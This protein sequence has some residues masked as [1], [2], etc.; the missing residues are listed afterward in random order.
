MSMDA[1]RRGRRRLPV[2]GEL[3]APALL[4]LAAPIQARQG[5]HL[6][7]SEDL[8]PR[9]HA[10][11]SAVRE[12]LVSAAD[13]PEGVTQV[14]SLDHLDAEE[15][16]ELW[17]MLGEG[18]VSIV[19][20]GT[21]R[22]EIEET[23]LPGVFRVRTRRQDGDSLHLEVGTIPAVVVVAAHHGTS[24]EM[25]LEDP[26]PPGLMNAQPLLAELKHR[27]ATA[28]I[29]VENHVVSLSLLPMNDADSVYLARILG[30]G[31][32]KA[33]SRGYGTCRVTATSRRGI[34]SVQHFNAMDVLVLDTLEIGTVP[35]ALL[36]AAMDLEDSGKRLGELLDDVQDAS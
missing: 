35:T 8:S 25:A 23:A 16:A 13:R 34:W 24:P 29:G 31:P 18:E 17:D 11:L 21:S 5:I 3:E 10:L 30:A 28:E 26:P 27:S 19:V 20:Q 12:A 4:G 9:A 22:Y 32:I 15:R 7:A 1:E 33:E 6:P 14:F 36:A 2:L